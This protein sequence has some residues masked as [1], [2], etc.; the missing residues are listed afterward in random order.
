VQ[1]F[2]HGAERLASLGRGAAP[3]LY[4]DDLAAVS[5]ARRSSSFNFGKFEPLIRRAT[6]WRRDLAYAAI[7]ALIRCTVPATEQSGA[8]MRRAFWRKSIA[9]VHVRLV[10]STSGT[11]HYRG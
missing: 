2:Q 4:P 6:G 5:R 11:N 8:L 1:E 10:D 7:S 3:L 9:A